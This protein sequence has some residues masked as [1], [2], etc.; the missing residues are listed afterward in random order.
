MFHGTDTHSPVYTWRTED[1][2]SE[3]VFYFHHVGLGTQA[4]AIWFGGEVMSPFPCSAFLMSPSFLSLMSLPLP[5]EE[6][7]IQYHL[8]FQVWKPVVPARLR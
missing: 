3:F 4:Q 6:I 5:P 8:T 2:F 1:N 7:A